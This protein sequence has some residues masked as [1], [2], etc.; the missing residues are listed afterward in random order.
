MSEDSRPEW[1]TDFE[2]P[3]AIACAHCGEA[4]CEGCAPT[5]ADSWRQEGTTEPDAFVPPW[6]QPNFGASQG[7]RDTAKVTVRNPK[8]AFGQLS[9]GSVWRALQFSFWAE[10]WAV[11]SYSV[12]WVAGVSVAFPFLSQH[13][14]TTR[15]V[16]L[17][18]ASIFFGLILFVIFVHAAWGWL[19]EWSIGRLGKKPAYALGLRFGLYAC[20]WD[21]ITSPAGFYLLLG[22]GPR[23][24]FRAFSQGAKVP[25]LAVR[26]YLSDRR[27]LS[28][29]E[30]KKVVWSSI[31]VLGGV[32]VAVGLSFFVL[33]LSIWLP[34]LLS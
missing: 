9:E 10:F 28:D 2:V 20:G 34:I 30:R 6:E 18:A 32:S 29:Q 14:L 31:L 11:G 24:A 4:S 27:N 21:L 7:L 13:L 22:E 5:G 8:L 16:L 26:S 1:G 15:S 12:L 33:L 3:P 25:K 23:Q 17:L 19:L